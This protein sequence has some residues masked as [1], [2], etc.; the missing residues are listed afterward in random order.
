MNDKPVSDTPSRTDIA[1]SFFNKLYR[2][3][4]VLIS[5]WWVLITCVALCVGAILA[6]KLNA[7][8]TFRSIGRMMVVGK[9]GASADEAN[10]FYGTQIS[11]MNSEIISNR[12]ILTLLT[13]ATPRTTTKPVKLH[14]TV[15]PKTSIFNLEATSP[16]GP[17]A[18]AFLGAV[19]TN[20]MGLKKEMIQ[21]GSSGSETALAQ[22][23]TNIQQEIEG[24]KKNLADFET[25]NSLPFLEARAQ[26]TA[27]YINDLARQQANLKSELEMLDKLTDDENVERQL[28]LAE[29]TADTLNG[30]DAI[31]KSAAPVAT[32]AIN[33][34]SVAQAL[35]SSTR[36][37]LKAKQGIAL[38]EK[39]QTEWGQHFKPQ[40]PRMIALADDINRRKQLLDVFRTQSQQQIENTKRRSQLEVTNYARLIAQN[41]TNAI[42]ISKKLSE[43]QTIKESIT[44]AQDRLQRLNILLYTT[45]MDPNASQD[46]VNVLEEASPA[47]PIPPNL[48]RWIAV[49]SILG[50]IMGIGI[51]IALDTL[52]DRPT[53]LVELQETIDEEI[54]G[55]IPKIHSKDKKSPG[56]L[57]END[58]RH[59]LIEAYRN[60]RSSILFL[61]TPENHPRTLLITSAIPA[62]GKS[63]TSANLAITL[64]R[65]GGR[66]LL[67]DADLRRGVMHER[68][69]CTH[70]PGFSE[71]LMDQ[72]D[73]TQAIL[74]TQTPGLTLLPRGSTTRHPGELFVTGAKDKFLKDIEGKYDYILFDTAPVMAAD[75]VSNLAPYVDGVIMVIRANHTSGR[76]ARAALEILY[77]RKTNLLGVV[78]NAVR[79]HSSEYYYYH[80]KDYYAKDQ[81]KA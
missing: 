17:Y 57:V 33:H 10:N 48:G 43:Y 36:D 66:V 19:M 38:A 8:P 28:N 47:L 50:L 76:V 32:D 5:K 70:K 23:M 40:H 29:Q 71:V 59:A 7:P 54:L 41:E 6:L 21:R 46:I 77:Q 35:V 68:F 13:N 14:I 52:D 37:Y 15:T 69:G 72:C 30:T 3:L 42:L 25:T 1:S 60:L 53:S 27:N 73:W 20:Y 49:A 39:R 56:I 4:N 62:D 2:Y 26:N 44:L 55:Q 16:D 51:L 75:D 11:M 31:T 9:I 63:M 74:Q 67:V 79:A 80:Y 18:Q 45:K 34:S 12:A 65:S 58:D 78:F 81:P 61:G 22:E 64:A 24:Y